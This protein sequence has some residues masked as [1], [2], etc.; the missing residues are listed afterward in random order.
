MSKSEWVSDDSKVC[1]R[2]RSGY[3]E[4]W[5]CGGESQSAGSVPCACVWVYQTG[6]LCRGDTPAIDDSRENR[7]LLVQYVSI[8]VI[9]IEN[10][11]FN[12]NVSSAISTGQVIG[13]VSVASAKHL[14]K[15]V[16]ITPQTGLFSFRLFV[17]FIR[18][19]AIRRSLGQ[20]KDFIRKVAIRRSLGQRRVLSK[21]SKLLEN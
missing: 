11:F 20:R 6:C 8:S 1:V 2:G 19:V 21:S 4:L 14:V 15:V 5:V 16:S 12:Q 13:A 10:V 18:K 9:A 17:H 3:C 7:G